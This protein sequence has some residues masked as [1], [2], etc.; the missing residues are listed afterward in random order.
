MSALPRLRRERGAAAL[1][2]ALFLPLLMAFA[3]GAYIGARLMIVHAD[4]NQVTAATARYATRAALDPTRPQSYAFR[5]TEADVWA[6]AEEI[7]GFPIDEVTVEP[8]PAKTA[9]GKEVTVTVQTHVD[10]GPFN[11]V[12]G[13]LIND[14]SCSTANAVCLTSTATMR[15]E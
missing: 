5:P 12:F 14:S 1:E 3:A 8:D 11:A 9:P 15:E 6:Y 4:L 7:A 13:P 10:L 2:L